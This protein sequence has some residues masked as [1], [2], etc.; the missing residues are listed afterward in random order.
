MNRAHS[1]RGPVRLYRRVL[2]SGQPEVC[3]RSEPQRRRA[4]DVRNRA[5][6]DSFDSSGRPEYYLLLKPPAS[7]QVTDD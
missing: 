6:L 5:G 4:A 3:I 1:R 7:R 2:P